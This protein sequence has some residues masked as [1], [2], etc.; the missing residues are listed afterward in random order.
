MC[1]GCFVGKHPKKIYE[2]GKEKRDASTLYIIRGD[3]SG[4]MSTTSMN[5]YIYFLT[6]IDDC[7]RYCWVYFLKQN[8]EVFDTFK[9]F[10]S[11][12]QNTLKNNIKA[13]RFDNGG[14]YVKR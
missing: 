5:G 7:S 6:F 12:A 9:I 13:L 14:D 10:K 2:L 11:L 1:I 8:S 3:V 4:L